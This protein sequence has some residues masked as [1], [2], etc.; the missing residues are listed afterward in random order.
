M[1]TLNTMKRVR[2]DRLML[3]INKLDLLD[4]E[5]VQ[6]ILDLL[7]GHFCLSAADIIRLTGF[8]PQTVKHLLGKLL[9]YSYVRKASEGAQTGYSINHLHLKKVSLIAKKLA[10]FWEA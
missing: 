5:E 9:S 8:S 1:N 4:Q 7:E 3:A 10:A 6:T 2:E